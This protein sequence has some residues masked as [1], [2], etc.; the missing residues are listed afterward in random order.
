MVVASVDNGGPVSR[1]G[2]FYNAGS[3]YESGEHAGVTHGLR[4][5]ADI[6][7]IIRPNVA[8]FSSGSHVSSV[9]TGRN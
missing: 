2:I 8:L 6:V 3:R 7:S 9:F 5:A 4:C 1:V